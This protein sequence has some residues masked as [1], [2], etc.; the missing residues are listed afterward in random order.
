[1]YILGQFTCVHSYADI[2]SI[3]PAIHA[4]LSITVQKTIEMIS[5]A[6]RPVVLVGSQ[7]TLPPVPIDQLRKALEVS[8]KWWEYSH[9]YKISQAKRPVVLVGSQATLP[10]VPIDQLRKALEVSG[11]WLELFI[12][13][14]V[15]V[16]SVKQSVR[17]VDG[18]SGNA[19]SRPHRPTTQST[20]GQWSVIRTYHTFV[21]SVMESVPGCCLEVVQ[22]SLPSKVSGK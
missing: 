1:M 5:R 22:F 16:R 9:I 11:Q 20:R 2:T 18:K 19:P 12:H 3:Y 15:Q 17:G 6:K 13:V 8:G 14:H 4:F 7:A 21:R 10:P